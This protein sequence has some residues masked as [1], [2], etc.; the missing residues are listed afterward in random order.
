MSNPGEKKP[1]D[2]RKKQL[3]IVTELNEEEL[4]NLIKLINGIRD[5]ADKEN[6]IAELSKMKD[7]FPNLALYLWHANGIIAILLQDL[8]SIYQML[9]PPNTLS[10]SAANVVCNIL[11]LIQ[12]LAAH[13]DT[14]SLLLSAHIPLF[15]F[16]FLNTLNK[17]SNYDTIRLTSLGVI[18]SLVKADSSE[19]INYLLQTEIIPL[20]LRIMERG[21]DLC[22]LISTFIIQKILTDQGGLNYICQ[23]PERFYVINTVLEKLLKKQA[24][25]SPPQKRLLKNIIRCY[26]KL[27]EN[28]RANSALKENIPSELN[29]PRIVSALDENS[30]KC[31]SNLFL[32]LNQVNI[33][34]S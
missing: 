29:D 3:P 4:N 33:N 11:S 27:S 22:Q 13:K 5:S 1:N 8:I 34:T 32:N 21:S 14:R 9:S 16:P 25:S 19:V 15:L 12:C 18:G 6:S 7:H 20:C 30:K 26:L 24:S 28:T 17:N 10:S 31:L 2:D 23:K